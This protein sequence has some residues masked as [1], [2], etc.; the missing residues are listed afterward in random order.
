[1][2]TLQIDF[3]FETQK[4]LNLSLL[5]FSNSCSEAQVK[6][7]EGS[8]TRDVVCGSASRNHYC[9]ISVFLL[10]IAVAPVITG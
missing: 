4:E 7:K 5:L 2:L 8:M 10:A 3:A 9:A 1:M 6:L